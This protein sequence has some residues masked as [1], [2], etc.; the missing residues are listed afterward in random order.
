MNSTK[1]KYTVGAKNFKIIFKISLFMKY[2]L[3]FFFI[4]HKN[5]VSLSRPKNGLSVTKLGSNN[6]IHKIY[7]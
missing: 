6:D 2:E 4:Q 3:Q 5:V 1:I 7:L